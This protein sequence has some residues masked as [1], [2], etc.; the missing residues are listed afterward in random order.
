MHPW[1]LFGVLAVVLGGCQVGAPVSEGCV[2]PSHL[3]S[4]THSDPPRSARASQGRH[5]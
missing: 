3:P 5:L 2:L 1:W 4:A